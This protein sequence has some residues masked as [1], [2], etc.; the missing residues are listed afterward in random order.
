MPKGYKSEEIDGWI[1][2]IRER[3]GFWDK[4]AE[5]QGIKSPY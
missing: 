2:Y 5:E 1:R 4:K 3:V